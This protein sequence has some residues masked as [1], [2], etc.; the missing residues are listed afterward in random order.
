MDPLSLTLV[1]LGAVVA[2]G[3]YLWV[4]MFIIADDRSPDTTIIWLIVLLALPVLGLVLY[5][6]LGKNHRQEKSPLRKSMRLAMER[7]EKVFP[8]AHEPYRDFGRQFSSSATR[9]IV[10]TSQLIERSNLTAV[11][12]ADEVIIFDQ[13]QDFFDRLKTQ[14]AGAE[15]YIHMM[16]FIWECDD[17]TRELTDILLARLRAGVEVRIL[18][19]AIG[20]MFYG[21]S[22]LR[23]LEQAGAKIAMDNTAPF[24]FNFRNHHK[25]TVIDGKVSFTGGHNVGEEYISGG[26]KYDSWRDTSIE[27]TGP[28]LL[29]L[30]DIFALRWFLKTGEDL[31]EAKY[32]PRIPLPANPKAVQM[33]HSSV[34]FTWETIKQVYLKLI[35]S[36]NE[37][38]YIQSPY[39]VPDQSLLDALIT[40][41]LSGV[42]V[43]L[44]MTGVPD[45]KVSWWAAKAYFRKPLEAGMKIYMYDAGFLHAKTLLVDDEVVSIGTT[46]FDMRSFNLQKENTCLIYHDQPTV[47]QH[48]AIYR[49]DVEGCS[50]FTLDDYLAMSGAVR[51]RNGLC[52]IPS[53]LF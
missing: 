22:E 41:S 5:Y 13:G 28:A 4:I 9:D 2:I 19:D 17:L 33:T 37:R 43:Q 15:R 40:A 31:Y 25:I 18:R 34:D 47:D 42:D 36:A 51:L 46:N 7:R 6:F 21:K 29:D 1:S 16:Y 39:F 12:P 26:K 11:L 23:E 3:Y 49:R 38:V 8:A 14:L 30:Q 52:K 32:F 35:V 48:V 10:T 24:L 20:S 53:R 45:K 27:V 44:M 50:P